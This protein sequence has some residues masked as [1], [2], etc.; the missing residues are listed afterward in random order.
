MGKF[1]AK[2]VKIEIFESTTLVRDEA[3]PRHHHQ[4]CLQRSQRHLPYWS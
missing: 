3:L 2:K 1:S 4:V